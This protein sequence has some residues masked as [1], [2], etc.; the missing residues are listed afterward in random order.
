MSEEITFNPDPAQQAAAMIEMFLDHART[1]PE[2]ECVHRDNA[3]AIALVVARMCFLTAE[4]Q[5]SPGKFGGVYWA[6]V[7]A[8]LESVDEEP[9]RDHTGQII[10]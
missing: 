3:K 10:T 7:M 2:Y 5:Y 1:D 8:E 6:E 4:H 9:E